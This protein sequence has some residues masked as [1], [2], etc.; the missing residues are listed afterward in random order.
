MDFHF[1]HEL[2]KEKYYNPLVP[3]REAG[4]VIVLLYEQWKTGKY[5]SNSFSEEI[6]KNSIEQVSADLGKQ[7]ERTPHERFKDINLSLQK[8]FLLRNEETNLYKISQYGEE[9]CERIKEKLSREFNPSDIEKILADLIVSLKKYIGRNDLKHWYKFNFYPQ[10]SNIK[11]QVETLLRQVENSVQ[12]FRLSIKSDDQT[13][14]ETVRQ[15][16]K[17]LQVIGNHAKELK[18][19]FFDSEEIKGLILQ[20]SFDNSPPEIIEYKNAVRIFFEEVNNDLNIVG[21][22]IERIRPKL[23][24]FISSINQRNFDRNTE[25]FLKFLLQNTVITK[26]NNKKKIKLPKEI[27]LKI[28]HIPE[29]NFI[30]V[31]ANRLLPKQPT[32]LILPKRDKIKRSQQ[33]Q[34]A[35]NGMFIKKRIRFWLNEFEKKIKDQQLFQFSEFYYR[36]L[37]NEKNHGNTIALKVA[38]GVF[39]K[40]TKLKKYNV[41]V[42]RKMMV[43]NKYPSQAIWKMQIQKLQKD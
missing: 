36:I 11:N 39:R 40:Y 24:Q 12:E 27:P 13:F 17:N 18:D 33:L 2:K 15:V 9:F 38:S 32:P 37:D 16:D 4:L 19:A 8:Y 10:K 6:I 23:R 7:Y 28:I 43:N 14:L 1:Y 42:E 25:N 20:L 30:I 34:K 26:D 22:R 21:H 5:S 29:S 35:Q 3:Q 31:E 41:Q